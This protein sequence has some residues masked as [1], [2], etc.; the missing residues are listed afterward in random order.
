MRSIR[1]RLLIAALVFVNLTITCQGHDLGD[2][3]SSLHISVIVLDGEKPVPG[4]SA[5]AAG[6][7]GAEESSIHG[8]ATAVSSAGRMLAH[9]GG[10][11]REKG[12]TEAASSPWLPEPSGRIRVCTVGPDSGSPE[13]TG[14]F[15]ISTLLMDDGP[16]EKGLTYLEV[17]ESLRLT[18]QARLGPPPPP[19]RVRVF[20]LTWAIGLADGDYGRSRL[21]R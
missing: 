16:P 21:H 15:L 2:S 4:Q 3:H 5:G 19:P 11:E 12:V 7:H 20:T 10:G 18:A 6:L 8:R 14:L 9:A 17:A 13:G 1:A